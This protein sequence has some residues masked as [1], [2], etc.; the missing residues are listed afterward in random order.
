MSRATRSQRQ[1]LRPFG[2]PDPQ[3]SER[4]AGPRGAQDPVAALGL[5]GQADSSAQSRERQAEWRES[6]PSR[7]SP[8]MALP[9][10]PMALR[11]WLGPAW[12]QSPREGLFGLEP[13]ERSE[14]SKEATPEMGGQEG[15]HT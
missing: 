8:S 11:L 5:R 15:R 6:Q 7:I 14:Q 4:L 1:V 10:C 3:P 9:L 13:H 2:P 12:C